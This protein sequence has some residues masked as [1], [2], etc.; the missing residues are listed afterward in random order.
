MGNELEEVRRGRTEALRRVLRAN[1]VGLGRHPRTRVVDEIVGGEADIPCDIVGDTEPSELAGSVRLCS[2]PMTAS[3]PPRVSS[4]VL[5]PRV[6]AEATS[7]S[8]ALP[9]WWPVRCRWRPARPSPWARRATL[10]MRTLL[11]RALSWPLTRQEKKTSWLVSMSSAVRT[12]DGP[13]RRPAAD[14][15][16]RAEGPCPRRTRYARPAQAPA[17]TRRPRLRGYVRRG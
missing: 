8:L 6:P 3:F 2:A 16:R 14:G 12:I 17:V 4:S 5:Q 9:A 11:A 1:R 10:S 13:N 7:W 15:A